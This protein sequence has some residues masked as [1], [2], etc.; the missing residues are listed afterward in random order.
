LL[1]SSITP[2][3]KLTNRNE[4]EKETIPEYYTPSR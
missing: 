1:S 4:S 2:K 3:H